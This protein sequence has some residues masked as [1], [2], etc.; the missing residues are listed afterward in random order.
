MPSLRH[1]VFVEIVRICPLVLQD[2]RL[3][4]A[5]DPRLPPLPSPA[6]ATVAAEPI[7]FSKLTPEG[8]QPKEADSVLVWRSKGGDESS[9]QPKAI[10]TLL[11][12]VQLNRAP[13]HETWV[14]YAAYGTVYLTCPAYV[15]VIPSTDSLADW[16]RKPCIYG[17][18]QLTPAVLTPSMIPRIVDVQEVEASPAMTLLA[19][20]VHGVEKDDPAAAAQISAG[21]R[22]TIQLRSPVIDEYVTMLFNSVFTTTQDEV[23]AMADHYTSPLLSRI[24]DEARREGSIALA[25]EVKLQLLAARFKDKFTQDEQARFEKADVRA[26]LQIVLSRFNDPQLTL[27]QVFN[28]AQ[29]P[30]TVSADHAQAAN[31]I[32]GHTAGRPKL[33]LGRRT[34]G[35]RARKRTA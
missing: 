13:K 20:V 16:A 27:E 34:R 28:A 32:N 26:V 1:Q 33:K 3:L 8:G 35:G 2:P 14:I 22:A 5:F 4:A 18:L 31:G 25:R 19:L 29:P 9:G 17:G 21:D 6:E 7:S 30:S 10:C 23:T 11:G 24:Q 12:E 15:A